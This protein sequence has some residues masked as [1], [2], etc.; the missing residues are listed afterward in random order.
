MS[1]RGEP[2]SVHV[3][4]DAVVVRLFRS[5]GHGEHP[6]VGV[7]HEGG[8]LQGQGTY[9]GVH[10]ADVVGE[11]VPLR[12]GGPPVSG[13]VHGQ[14]AVPRPEARTHE[15]PVGQVRADPVQQQ[16]GRS[17]AAVVPDGQ[18]Q[19]PVRDGEVSGRRRHAPIIACR[20]GS[21][22]RG[23]KA[24]QRFRKPHK[25]APAEEP[26]STR[27]LASGVTQLVAPGWRRLDADALAAVRR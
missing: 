1:R 2:H 25:Q 27:A 17:V 16:H 14:D 8:R 13:Q 6:A 26:T 15:R 3:D 19:V 10:G 9:D 24:S 12:N 23:L 4:R 5:G 20:R 21:R 22:Y 18:R 7:P 11:R